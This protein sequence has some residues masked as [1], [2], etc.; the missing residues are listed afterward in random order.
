MSQSREQTLAALLSEGLDLCVRARK[1]DEAVAKADLAGGGGLDGG[2]GT[3]SGTPALWVLDA[4]ER[5]LA[6]WEN[7]GRHELLQSGLV[8]RSPRP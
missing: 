4:Y 5:D 1:L 3:R 6:S 7:R 2:T 8:D